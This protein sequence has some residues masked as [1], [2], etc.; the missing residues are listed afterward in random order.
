MT[1][2]AMTGDRE[3]CLA[4][5]MDDYLSK[6]IRPA[7]LIAAVERIAARG[8]SREASGSGPPAPAVPAASDNGSIFDPKQALAR[9]G[10]DRQLLRQLIRIFRT[11]VRP[12]MATIKRTAEDGEA[13]GLRRSAHALKGSLGTIGAPRVAETA[14][15]LE[16]LAQE[17]DLAHASQL[18][19]TL[20][21]QLRELDGLMS[22]L[23]PAKRRRAV[24]ARVTR[25][26]RRAKRS[27]R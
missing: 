5:G 20:A 22:P 18:V 17:G 14:R 6:P 8:S 3:R 21:G 13:D 24:R 4:A 9:L 19:D 26:R 27:R 15:R 16:L 7:D 2:H 23:R 1:A 25:A 10:G 12:L 11:D